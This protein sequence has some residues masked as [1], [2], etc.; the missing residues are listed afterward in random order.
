MHLFIIFPHLIPSRMKL[1]SWCILVQLNEG[2]YGKLHYGISYK[3]EEIQ[4]DMKM[5]H[6]P[7]DIT[8]VSIVLKDENLFT[9]QVQVGY[10]IVTT[11]VVLP[12]LL[13]TDDQATVMCENSACLS[14]LARTNAFQL[15]TC[16]YHVNQGLFFP[17]TLANYTLQF[18]ADLTTPPSSPTP[19][20]TAEEPT[21]IPTIIMST[22]AP[23]PIT[24]TPYPVT[25]THSPT[26]TPRPL[27]PAPTKPYSPVTNP[28]S[29]TTPTATPDPDTSY[30]S[31]MTPPTAVWMAL[32]VFV[33][34][35][36][37]FSINYSIF[38]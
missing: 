23:Y 36:Q 24:A 25:T 34:L 32:A 13:P 29:T 1:V 19:T 28:P 6:V 12:P 8:A 15:P 2:V 5:C 4:N 3:V 21:I 16:V 10:K 9:C 22:S 17:S 35:F 20:P 31:S 14:F 33:F 11:S 7:D 18:C 30:A 27:T 26:A 38:C 37:A